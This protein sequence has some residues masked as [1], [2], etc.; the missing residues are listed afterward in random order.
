MKA[1]AV[2]DVR[3]NLHQVQRNSRRQTVSSPDLA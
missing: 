3:V 2:V 1:R